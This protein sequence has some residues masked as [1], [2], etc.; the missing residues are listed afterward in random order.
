[1]SPPPAPAGR[2]FLLLLLLLLGDLPL[3]NFCFISFLFIMQ[4]NLFFSLFP[5]CP[6][7]SKPKRRSPFV[8]GCVWLRGGEAE[9]WT[10]GEVDRRKGGE[11]RKRQ[12]LPPLPPPPHCQTVDFPL[13][14]SAPYITQPPSFAPDTLTPVIYHMGAFFFFFLRPG[15]DVHMRVQGTRSFH[16]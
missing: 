10:G 9:R 13:R 15:M 14:P 6:R 2:L 16:L 11:Q 5:S 7:Q 1:M 3:P 4:I 8:C 12:A